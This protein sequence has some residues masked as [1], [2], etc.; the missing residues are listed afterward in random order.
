MANRTFRQPLGSLEVDV[1]ELFCDITVGASGAPSP[2]AGTALGYG[3]GISSV[4]R[5]SAGRYTIALQDSY[6][7]LLMIETKLSATTYDPTA[8]ASGNFLVSEQVNS[9]TAPGFVIQFYKGSDGSALDVASGT[10]VLLWIK[11]RNS[12]VQ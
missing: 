6:N 8:S 1:V 7:K 4:T 5:N 9:S 3:K 2:T 10:R 11:T 12:S